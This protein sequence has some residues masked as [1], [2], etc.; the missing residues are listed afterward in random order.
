M[1]FSHREA[2]LVGQI[3]NCLSDKCLLL[4]DADNIC[5][6]VRRLFFVMRLGNIPL[7]TAY[8]DEEFYPQTLIL[9]G[10][11]E[12][13]GLLKIRDILE[14]A[15]Y[16]IWEAVFKAMSETEEDTEFQGVSICDNV[17]KFSPKKDGFK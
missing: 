5:D 15:R 13:Y 14:A 11:L 7:E 6:E 17:V 1:R 8:N 2:V 16:G 9:I 12:K 10:M 3:I 4:E